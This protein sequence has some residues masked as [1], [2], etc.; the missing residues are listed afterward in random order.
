MPY[1]NIEDRRAYYRSE[2]HRK[3]CR[4]YHWRHR[5]E[6]SARKRAW[7]QK[8]KDRHKQV[9]K[10]WRE[11]NRYGLPRLD[12]I[13]GFDYTSQNCFRRFDEK[14]LHIHHTNP[15]CLQSSTEKNHCGHVRK[16]CQTSPYF[17]FLHFHQIFLRCHL[18]L[19]FQYW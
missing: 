10:L 9:A 16:A 11:N 6:I 7:Y 13:K 17:E 19:H 8:N 18:F 1:K 15:T 14:D 2:K 3:S 12:I 5:D 4:K